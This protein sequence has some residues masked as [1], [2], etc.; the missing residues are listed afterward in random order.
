M[1]KI[2]R[3]KVRPVLIKAWRGDWPTAEEFLVLT[4]IVDMKVL[5]EVLSLLNDKEITV[6]EAEEELVKAE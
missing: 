3:E 2:I 1:D 5:V 6:N 4:E